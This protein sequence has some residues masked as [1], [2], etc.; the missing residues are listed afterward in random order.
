VQ[1]DLTAEGS[2]DGEATFTLRRD[3]PMK[4][5]LRNAWLPYDV[6]EVRLDNFPAILGRGS[7]CDIS[8][9][10]EF[11]SR[12]HCRFVRRGD[13]VLVQ[14]LASLNGTFVNERPAGC[15]T[16]IRPGDRLRLGPMSFRVS[17]GG[18]TPIDVAAG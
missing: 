15:P 11:I 3:I 18:G 7:T 1:T 12:R 6:G 2:I 4:I 8:V 9:P 17:V 13:E 14:D 10:V 5:R 16:P